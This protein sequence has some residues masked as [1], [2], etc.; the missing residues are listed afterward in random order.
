MRW[1]T[2]VVVSATL[3]AT[4]CSS[5]SGTSAGAVDSGGADGSGGGVDSGGGGSDSGGGADAG[6]G[7]DGATGSCT[8]ACTGANVACDPAD[9]KCK[10]DGTTTNVGGTCST[11]GADPKCGTAPNATCND[12]TQDGFPGGY[13]SVEPC[14]VSALCP[15]GATCAHLNGESSACWKIC[16]TGADCRAP[17]YGCFDVTPLFTSGA[18]HKVCALKVF[19][20]NTSADCPTIKPT[21][22]GAN[23]D[24]GTTGTCG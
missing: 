8:P 6:R 24:A 18:S 2:L 23:V 12:L 7:T 5:S 16:A 3:G 19:A 20:C 1:M 10:P 4:A 14:S 9:N 11:S 22:S 17:D 13:C 15:I 21:C